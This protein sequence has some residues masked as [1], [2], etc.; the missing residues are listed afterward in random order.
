M[1]STKTLLGRAFRVLCLEWAAAAP[2]GAA[3]APAELRARIER[4]TSLGVD[5]ALVAQAG[6]DFVDPRLGARPDVEG[7]LFLLLSDGAEAYVLGPAGPR[8]IERRAVSP[9]EDEQLVGK[10]GRPLG[11]LLDLREVS[12]GR[13]QVPGRFRAGR[14][15]GGGDFLGDEGDVVEN[16]GEQVVEVMRNPACELAEALQTLGLRLQSLLALQGL[17][18]RTAISV[19]LVLS[20]LAHLKHPPDSPEGTCSAEQLISTRRDARGLPSPLRTDT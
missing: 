3:A 8:L 11:G 18:V 6:I 19:S 1:D 20:A 4:L 12:A 15:R 9:G 13:F 7:R 2:P 17:P 10:P 16:H 14:G 5:V